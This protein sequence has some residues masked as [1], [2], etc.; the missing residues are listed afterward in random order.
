MRRK[1]RV[2]ADTLHRVAAAHH[3]RSRMHGRRAI[4]AVV[5]LQRDLTSTR[6]AGD[7]DVDWLLQ[8]LLLLLP[9]TSAGTLAATPATG[10]AT[11]IATG[12]CATHRF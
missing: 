3:V 12:P 2:S 5:K 9:A 6:G 7:A 11:T 1:Q 10:H 8:L 4:A